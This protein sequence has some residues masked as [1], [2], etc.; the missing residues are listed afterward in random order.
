M[1]KPQKKTDFAL[2]LERRVDAPRDRVW[3]AWTDPAEVKKWWG[4]GDNYAES[5]EMDVRVG[6]RFRIVMRGAEGG[7]YVAEGT[8][9]EVVPSVKLV[10]TWMWGDGAWADIDMRVT[11]EFSDDGDGT[12]IVLTHEN[13]PDQEACDIHNQGWTGQLGSMEKYILEG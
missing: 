5:V 13:F 1:A 12:K 7:R 11:I 6:G 3:R 8:Y 4:S 2:T 10:H 9:E